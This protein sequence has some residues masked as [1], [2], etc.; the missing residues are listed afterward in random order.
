MKRYVVR[1]TGEEREQLKELVAKGRSSARALTR[2]RILLRTDQGEQGECWSDEQ[3]AAAL[4]CSVGM[5]EQVRERFVERG[6]EAIQHKQYEHKPVKVTGEVEAKLV[7]LACTQAP[8]GRARWTLQL[9]ADKAVE[10]SYVDSI[11]DEQV[12]RVLK[13][14]NSSRGSRSSG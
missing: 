12:R 5:C 10:L 11:S 8:E 6:L 7:A 9:L 2:A 13:K 14:T 4:D 3:V 1:L